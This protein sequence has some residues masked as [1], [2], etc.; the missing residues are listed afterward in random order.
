MR[1]TNLL[2]VFAKN[3]ELGKVKTRLAKTVG[4]EQALEIYSHLFQLTETIALQ[5]QE[6]DV[7]IYFSDKIDHK[8]YT[9]CL[10]F[11]QQGSDLG[12]RM[13]HA[14]AEG[15]EQGYARIV[16]IGTDLPD[17]STSILTEAFVA[18]EDKHV[19]IG[20]A[21]DGGYYLIGMNQC[22][23]NVFQN[24]PW[25]TESLFEVTLAE[26]NQLNY[27][28]EILEQLNDIDTFE[29]FLHSNLVKSMPHISA[30]F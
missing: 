16:G 17:L 25:S 29:D 1:S 30:L 11:V 18:L 15:F 12:E 7:H 20:P 2:I 3:I 14:F 13:H 28:V 21:Q 6:W 24:K 10:K 9:N 27:T 8:N 4:N 19:V 22:V 5:S 23:D 26:L